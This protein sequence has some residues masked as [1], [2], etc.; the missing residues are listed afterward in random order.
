MFKSSTMLSRA[1][2]YC[3]FRLSLSHTHPNL[4]SI[5]TQFVP[6]T[7]HPFYSPPESTKSPPESQELP[8]WLKLSEEYGPFYSESDGDF[9]IPEISDWARHQKQLCNDAN[10][11]IKSEIVDQLEWD[12]DE[13][14]KVMKFSY[15]APVD[16]AESLIDKC[17]GIT[18]S[19]NLVVKLLNR[20]ENDYVRAYGV[21]KWAKMQVGSEVSQGLYNQMVDILGKCK[22][23]EQMEELVDDMN[24]LGKGS[25]TLYTM[26]KVIRRFAKAGR[27][28]RAIEA[29]MKME[30]FDVKKDTASMNVLLDSLVKGGSVESAAEVF[31]GLE[32]EI[33]PNCQTYNI[34]I[35]GWCKARKLEEAHKVLKE[36]EKHSIC[37]DTVTYTSFIEAYCREKDFRKVEETLTEMREK[38]YWPSVVTYTIYVHSLGKAKQLNQAFEVYERMKRDNCVPDASFYSSLISHLGKSGRLDDAL[39]LYK[40][41]LKQGVIP[42]HTT[43]NSLISL[44]CLHSREGDALRL[45]FEMKK[46]SVKPDVKTYDPLLKICCRKNK[47]KV[48]AFLLNHMFRNDVSPEF[49]TYSLLVSE[50]CKIEK[51]EHACLFFEEMVRTGYTPKESLYESL[52]KFLTKKDMGRAKE[53]IGMLYS[54]KKEKENIDIHVHNIS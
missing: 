41:M 12:A 2:L 28:S 7:T 21:F 25:V 43:Y 16:V 49:G 3:H 13:V 48:L 31:L 52:M 9:E 42:N 51:P 4:P 32:S 5:N 24:H 44:Y 50:L 11:D 27:F 34:F 37:P 29:F 46:N 10:Y 26:T 19:E 15:Q 20:F 36:M 54:S 33:P 30:R 8:S 17:G 38:G 14:S 35:H 53:Q 6:F 45:L 1:K 39:D 47:L 22:K 23:F 18:A 40:D